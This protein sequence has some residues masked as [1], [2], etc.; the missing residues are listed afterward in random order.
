MSDRGYFVLLT[1]LTRGTNTLPLQTIQA[2]VAHYLAHV[3][4]SPTPLA[5]SVV[6][7]PFFRP[8]SYPKLETLETAFRHAV[9]IKI[10]LLKDEKGGLFTR[11]LVARTGDWIEDVLKGLEGGDSMLRLAC[12]CG[13][14]HGLHEREDDLAVS[15]SG[16]KHRVDEELIMALAEVM[17]MYSSAS[18]G[19]AREFKADAQGMVRPSVESLRID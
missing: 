7:S 19:W 4:P 3:Q 5:A 9:H 15:Q 8:I 1:H 2:S 12:T 17:D 16:M 18:G 13:L 14:E 10:K 11:S 6:S